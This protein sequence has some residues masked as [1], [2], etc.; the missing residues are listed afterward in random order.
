M[1][2]NEGVADQEEKGRART[3]WFD[4][5]VSSVKSAMPPIV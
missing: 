2:V 4:S 1:P 5:T 3:E